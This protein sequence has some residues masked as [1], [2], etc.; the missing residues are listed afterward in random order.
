MLFGQ[1]K[2]HVK[3]VNI[4]G[5]SKGCGGHWSLLSKAKLDPEVTLSLAKLELMYVQCKWCTQIKGGRQTHL[6]DI[7]LSTEYLTQYDSLK[8]SSFFEICEQF[9]PNNVY[10]LI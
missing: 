6:W 7:R 10:F 2:L 3:V 9:K 1:S 8:Q 4:V 5:T